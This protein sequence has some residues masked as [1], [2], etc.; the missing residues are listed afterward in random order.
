MGIIHAVSKYDLTSNSWKESEGEERFRSLA[1]AN[2]EP[3]L[4]TDAKDLN[5]IIVAYGSRVEDYSR[6]SIKIKDR[7]AQ[8]SRLISYI[9]GNS[10]L[11]Y[12]VNYVMLDADAPLVEQSKKLA[13]YID[14]LSANENIKSINLIGQSKCG[15]MNM[16]IPRFFTNERSFDITNVYNISTPYLGTLLASPLVFYPMVKEKAKK[17]F[18]DN[19]FSNFLYDCGINIYESISSN[20]HMDYDIAINKGV[21]KEKFDKYDENFVKNMLSYENLEALRKVNSFTN[22]TT[23]LDNKALNYAIR[24]G[25]VVTIGLY[26]LDT[27]FFNGESDGLVK[28]SDQHIIEDYLNI[29]STDLLASH[30]VAASRDFT[31]VLDS[32]ILHAV[33]QNEYSRVR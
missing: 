30:R 16:Y 5:Y 7:C 11:N 29:H 13:D 15:A 8:I 26:L 10:N 24:K 32:V 6:D 20:S 31:K 14:G 21:P 25:D 2:Y 3:V 19:K 28:T 12:I 17:A 33:E 22:F 18:G 9:N 27:W 1:V 23:F 4:N